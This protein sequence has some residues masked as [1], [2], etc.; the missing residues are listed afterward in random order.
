MKR[1]SDERNYKPNLLDSRLTGNPTRHRRQ[2]GGLG[3]DGG[4]HDLD[5]VCPTQRSDTRREEDVEDPGHG[6]E[7]VTI[8]L[9]TGPLGELG[10][11]DGGADEGSTRT[12]VSNDHG[13]SSTRLV[14]PDDTGGLGEQ[15]KDRVDRLKQ[16]S[17]VGL[18][19][20]SLKDTA[21]G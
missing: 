21:T 2:G 17:G 1:E 18:E 9:G 8:T 12:D 6:D 4:V 5:R 19:T 16:E 10:L 14:D 13:P 3:S 15:G 20:D 7:S 11:N